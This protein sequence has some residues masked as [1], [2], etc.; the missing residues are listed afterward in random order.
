MQ[1]RHKGSSFEYEEKRDANLLKIYREVLAKASV[2]TPI[3]AICAAVA[4]H[5]CDRFWVSE[6]RTNIVTGMMA[7]NMEGTLKGMTPLKRKMY[8]EIYSRVQMLMKEHPGMTRL[9]AVSEVISS[10]A[11]EFYLTPGSV[12]V[13]ICKMKK[14]AWYKE[15]K[16]KLRH[17]F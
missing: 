13:I 8:L 12:E 10:P 1:G 17:L 4:S 6:E 3:E 2:S 7:K 15:R 11:P 14:K 9:Q 16:R 5:E